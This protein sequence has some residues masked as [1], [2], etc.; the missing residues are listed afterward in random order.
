MSKVPLKIPSI[1]SP[2]RLL[3]PHTE[4]TLSPFS[5][6]RSVSCL[7]F[8]HTSAMQSA[9]GS[10]SRGGSVASGSNFPK[11]GQAST[12]DIY[13]PLANQISVCALWPALQSSSDTD[14]LETYPATH[15][16]DKSTAYY[17][18]FVP[19]TFGLCP[20]GPEQGSQ[21]HPGHTDEYGRSQSGQRP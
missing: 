17:R 3:A 20:K 8:D 9:L 11:G 5:R 14:L 10:A 2:T 19:P 7:T 15:L 6:F 18:P 13:R 1:G 21:L 4:S 16:N 12:L